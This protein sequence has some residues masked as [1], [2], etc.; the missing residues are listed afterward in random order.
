MSTTSKTKRTIQDRLLGQDQ[1]LTFQEINKF[2]RNKPYDQDLYRHIGHIF[3]IFVENN[4]IIEI[5][6]QFLNDDKIECV[7][8]RL[9]IDKF[10]EQDK[11]KLLEDVATRLTS[12]Q[13]SRDVIYEKI[14]RRYITRS[15]FDQAR[16]LLSKM[17]ESSSQKRY[18]TQKMQTQEEFQE[19]KKQRLL[20]TTPIQQQSIQVRIQQRDPRVTFKQIYDFLKQKPFTTRLNRHVS[21]I[22]LNSKM[23]EDEKNYDKVVDFSKDEEIQE[24][25]KKH[26]IYWFYDQNNKNVPLLLQF[27][28]KLTGNFK[29]SIYERIIERYIIIDSNL[30]DARKLLQSIPSDGLSNYDRSHWLGLIQ[31]K[32]KQVVK[33]VSGGKHQTK[34]NSDVETVSG[35]KR[36]TKTNSDSSTGLLG[37]G[38]VAVGVFLVVLLGVRY[39]K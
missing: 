34:Q 35:G 8:K 14:I 32:E 31:R 7:W 18:L 23:F 11:I 33:T 12:K 4:S 16:K 3:K 20:K 24:E 25:W 27:A 29:K 1:T 13:Q 5:V 30:E 10:Y 26:I 17:P 15:N 6:V 36:Q 39:R 38:A 22:I 37:L 21:G 2:L 9:L 28:T 19:R